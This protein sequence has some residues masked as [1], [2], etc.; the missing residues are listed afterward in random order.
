V[1]HEGL[2]VS[3]EVLQGKRASSVV[4]G[5]PTEFVR[6]RQHHSVRKYINK[7]AN[8]PG[9]AKEVSQEVLQGNRGVTS[10]INMSSMLTEVHISLFSHGIEVAPNPPQFTLVPS[11][12]HHSIL[13]TDILKFVNL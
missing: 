10:T 5:F 2:E 13:I 4:L 9:G 12:T 11:A 1:C 7:F 3:Q 8:S 6:N